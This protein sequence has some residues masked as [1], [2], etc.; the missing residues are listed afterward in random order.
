MTGHDYRNSVAAPHGAG[1][2]MQRALFTFLGHA[3]AGPF[4]AG[5]VVLAALILAPPLGL[6]ALLPDGLPNPGQAALATFVWA[7]V[8]ASLAGLALAAVAYLRGGYSWLVAAVAGGLAF[9][10]SAVALTLPSSL[11]LAPLTAF[12]AF[13]AIGVRQSLASARIIMAE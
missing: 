12:A 11:A 6:G 7:A 8:P 10:L 1:S 2:R 5:F 4:L 13:I 3:L 9:T